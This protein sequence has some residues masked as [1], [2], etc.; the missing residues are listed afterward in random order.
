MSL[1]PENEYRAS[2]S[3]G[4]FWDYVLLG[5]R[6]DDPIADYDPTDDPNAP[7]DPEGEG[8]LASPC[9]VCGTYLEACGYDVDGNAWVHCTPE[10]DE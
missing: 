7:M 4:E 5:R 3:D 2:L 9:P 10:D 6:P 1:C 8:Y